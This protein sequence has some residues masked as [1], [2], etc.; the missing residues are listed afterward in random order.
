MNDFPVLTAIVNRERTNCTIDMSHIQHIAE[1]IRKGK[2]TPS[3]K[4]F[5]NLDRGMGLARWIIM[6]WRK[7]VF[8]LAAYFY[9]QF[10][11]V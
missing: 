8:R 1:G 10:H 9:L 2:N 7:G 6:A 11:M 5:Y 3:R 4:S